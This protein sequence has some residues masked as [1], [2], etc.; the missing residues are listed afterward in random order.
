MWAGAALALAACASGQL[1]AP[2]QLQPAAAAELDLPDYNAEDDPDGLSRQASLDTERPLRPST[3]VIRYT[4]QP[5]DSV[6][7][8]ADKFQLDPE[9]ILWGNL[10]ALG[11]DPH[12]LLPGIELN[13]LPVDGVYY[14]WQAGDHLDRVAEQ[15]GVSADTIL[16]WPGNG[17]S[18]V[19][20]Q[21]DP[22][23]WLV[24]PGGER[25]FQN[26]H[27]PTIP[28]GSAG[29]G[30]VYGSGGCEQDILGGAVGSGGFIW[31]VANQ[32]ISGNDYWSGHLALDLAAGLGE[33]VWAADGG[34][35]VF[36]GGSYGGYG[37]IVAIDHGNDWQTV[38]AHLSALS[39]TC[40]QSVSQ[41]ELIGRA[42]STGYSTGPHLH[43]EVRFE[44]GFVNPRFV[45][46]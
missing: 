3:E 13:V 35:V 31:P 46:P 38:Y 34:V 41:G 25:A 2:S 20:P 18:P 42:G 23:D 22:G 16:D 43:F 6:F 29:V 4:V 11:D 15:F 24:V 17:L 37:M 32:V 27:V 8:I 19:A 21:I 12:A 45:L 1:A 40:G 14:Q 5:G 36:A 33:S 7:A 39:V 28:R 30:S 10:E 26:W 44:D 9:T